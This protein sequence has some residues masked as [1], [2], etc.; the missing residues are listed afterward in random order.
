M[1]PFKLRVKCTECSYK[2]TGWFPGI[3]MKADKHAS[4]K[5]HALSAVRLNGQKYCEIAAPTPEEIW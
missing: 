5:G 4:T 3:L 1:P 2:L